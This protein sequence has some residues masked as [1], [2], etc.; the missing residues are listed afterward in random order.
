LQLLQIKAFITG[1]RQSITPKALHT[2]AKYNT[3]TSMDLCS[4]ASNSVSLTWGDC[5]SDI[6]MSLMYSSCAWLWHVS[7]CI[8]RFFVSTSPKFFTFTAYLKSTGG[9][10]LI[11]IVQYKAINK[12]F[13]LQGCEAYENWKKLAWY[14]CLAVIWLKEDWMAI[15]FSLR[16]L[17]LIHVQERNTQANHLLQ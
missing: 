17:V 13:K 1:L 6:V 3:F 5:I 9:F 14:T 16:K 15:S 12:H 11:T 2:G 7:V 10:P 8:L 4:L